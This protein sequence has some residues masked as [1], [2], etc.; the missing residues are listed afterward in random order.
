MA[1][2]RPKAKS[3]VIIRFRAT[4]DFSKNLKEYVEENNTDIS[5]V[6]RKEVSRLW[7]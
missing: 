6:I 7:M 2:K 5:K 1:K 3:T 4:K